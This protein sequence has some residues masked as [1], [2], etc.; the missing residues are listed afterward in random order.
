MKP[1]TKAWLLNIL[2]L[3]DIIVTYIGVHL[4]GM[5]EGNKIFAHLVYDHFWFIAAFKI[6]GVF[7]I[8]YFCYIKSNEWRVKHNRKRMEF[9]INISLIYL[10]FIIAEWIL[11]IGVHLLGLF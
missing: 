6:M 3:G 1:I 4:L 5:K 9:P 2:N 7:L 10:S 11:F 8:V